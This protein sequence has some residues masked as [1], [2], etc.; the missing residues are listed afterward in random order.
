MAIDGVLARRSG[1]AALTVRRGRRRS[2]L[3]RLSVHCPPAALGS[4]GRTARTDG[5]QLLTSRGGLVTERS[6]E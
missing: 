6:E 2:L 3:A 4:D 1:S 5:V